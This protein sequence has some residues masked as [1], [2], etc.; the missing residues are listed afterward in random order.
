MFKQK[1]YWFSILIILALLYLSISYT[2]NARQLAEGFHQKRPFIL[3][4]GNEIYDSFY[5]DIY[6]KLHI[7]EEHAMFEYNKIIESTMPDKN[8]SNFLDIGAGTGDLVNKLTINGYNAHGI[9]SSEAMCSHAKSKYPSIDV[10]HTSMSSASYDINSFSHITCT[11]ST[12]YQM[13]DKS[14]FFRK[15]YN[16]LIPNGYLVLHLVDK[17]NFTPVVSCV[18]KMLDI[19]LSNDSVLKN[20]NNTTLDFTDF[21][22]NVTYK[23]EN[24][25]DELTIKET[26]TD[27][28][29]RHVRQ[30]EMTLN[31]ENIEKTLKIASN[32]GFIAHSKFKTPT[33]NHQFVYI[34][35]RVG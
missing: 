10:T 27:S 34:F 30:N 15:C 21:K 32:S 7:P 13:K 26:F 31:I 5:A 2:N 9:D 29:S 25:R 11:D 17:D 12:F 35:E 33:D 6:D 8:Q 20:I 22:Y 14:D 4:T 28:A 23:K 16:W 24:Q 1:Y 19:N 3:K 18:N